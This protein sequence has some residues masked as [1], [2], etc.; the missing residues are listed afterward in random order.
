MSDRPG[1]SWDRPLVVTCALSREQAAWGGVLGLACLSRF[2]D[3]GTRAMG[4]DE[5]IHAVLSFRL[6]QSGFYRHDPTYHGPLL[7][8]V[9]ALVYWL[10]GA[11]DTVARLA[12]ALAGVLLVATLWG[13]RRYLGRT[14]ALLAAVLVLVSPTLTFYSRYLREDVYACL[15]SLLWLYG[16]ARYL[17]ARRRRWLALVTAAMAAGFLSKEV[18]FIFGAIV[19]SFCAGLCAWHLWRGRARAGESAAG[20]LAALMLTLVLPFAAPV[21]LA[22]VGF[23]PRT[24][25]TRSGL[26]R[27]SV[28]VGLLLGASTLIAFLW[29]GR[30]PAVRERLRSPGFR[31]W[32]GLMGGFWTLQVLFFSTF[33]TNL[34]MGL[35]TGVVGSLGFWLGAHATA[36]GGQPWFY[37]LLVGGLYEFLPLLLGG[38]AAVAVARCLARRDPVAGPASPH[39]SEGDPLPGNDLLPLCLWWAAASWVAYTIAGEKMPWL[40]AHMVLPLCLLGGFGL[41]RLLEAIDWRTIGLRR[42]AGLAA[43][44]PI[45]LVLG[46]SAV[47]VPVFAGR[48]L[49]AQAEMPQWVTSV[50]LTLGLAVWG[51]RTLR[52]VGWAAGRRL[53]AVGL[54]AAAA[55][56]TVRTTVRLTYVNYDLATEPLVYAHGT[57]DIKRAMAEIELISQR[58]AG[59]RALQVA[60]DDQSAWPFSWY[61]RDYPR[62][63]SFGAVPTPDELAA[64]VILVGPRNAA[65]VEPF[66]RQG[67]VKRTYRAIWWPLEGYKDLSLAELGRILRD[68]IAR[69][70]LWQIV[71]DRRYPGIE[72]SE[73]PLR[74]GVA[75]YV[76]REVASR[77]WILGPG[78]P[79]PETGPDPGATTGRE[80]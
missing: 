52:R 10:L 72:L 45:L 49:H 57:P 29:F 44:T 33:L 56:L 24:Y 69:D 11:S 15:F 78:P 8:H 21:G 12:P 51:V 40:L 19:G 48:E 34:P 31:H 6:Y 64:P 59:D 75:M 23:D 5:S 53:V 41:A 25:T 76:S 62:A 50:L 1:S 37:Y 28:I 58:T 16:I 79:A 73:W 47:Q 9:N 38:G 26:A 71:S 13:F 43:G 65:Q 20:D 70:R 36:R 4:F 27:S 60:Y 3:L 32:A 55:L 14:A 46:A 80:R 54:V 42:A 22:L 35:A 7:Y 77:V 39:A 2:A 63:R 18:S 17:E 30:G 67:Y 66:V 61:L 74:R 68:P